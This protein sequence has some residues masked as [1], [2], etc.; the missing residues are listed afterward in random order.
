MKSRRV[1]AWGGWAL[2]FFL[3]VAPVPCAPQQS[4]RVVGQVYLPSGATETGGASVSIYTSSRNLVESTVTDT[5]G[6]FYF[7]GVPTGDYRLVVS[8]PGHLTVE[9]ELKVSYGVPEQGVT[10][11]LT[12]ESVWTGGKGKASVTAAELALPPKVRKEF[13]DGKKAVKKEKYDDAI[14]HLKAVTEAEPKFA[15][16]FEVLGVAYLR[17]EKTTEAEQAF[18][19][20]LELEPKQAECY[21]HLGLL[22]YQQRRYD[23]SRNFLKSGLAIDPTAWFGHYQLGLTAFALQKYA[24]SEEEFRR[25]EDLDPSF[26]EVHVRLGNVYL[27]QQNPSKALAEFESY[28][29]KD[30]KGSLAPRVRQVVSEMHSAGIKPPSM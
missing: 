16:G 6:H 5:R 23:E 4:T 26:L 13:E 12:P 11:F 22:C 28:L 10:V 8:K 14:D 24:E 18:K 9:Q 21:I 30:P 7:M 29:E 17:A 1:L 15:L 25:A 3:G 20:A 2:I 19:H 27:R